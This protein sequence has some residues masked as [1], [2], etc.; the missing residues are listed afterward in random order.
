M[1]VAYKIT[2]PLVIVITVLIWFVTDTFNQTQL[3][4]VKD[5]QEQTAIKIT[6]QFEK[7]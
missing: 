4:T 1:K 3:K 5:G 6:E 7:K 2:L